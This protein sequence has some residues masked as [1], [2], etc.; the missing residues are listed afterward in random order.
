MYFTD[1]YVDSDWGIERVDIPLEEWL[2]TEHPYFSLPSGMNLRL[3]GYPDRWRTL[4]L[5]WTMMYARDEGHHASP[6]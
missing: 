3:Q 2:D 5:I 1:D 4:R 6:F